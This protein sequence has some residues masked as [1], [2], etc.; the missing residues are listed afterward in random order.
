MKKDKDKGIDYYRNR[1]I[2]RVRQI[3][4]ERFLQFIDDLIVSF[5][6]KWGI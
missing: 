5:K 6:K 4:D 1:I 2:G 3:E